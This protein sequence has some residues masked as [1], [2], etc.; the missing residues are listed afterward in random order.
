VSEGT[1]GPPHP[2]GDA[3]RRLEADQAAAD[4]EQAAS[5]ADQ[6]ASDRDQAAADADQAASDRDQAQAAAD[7]RASDRDQRAADRD[8]ASR[9][10]SAEATRAYEASRAARREGTVE[11]AEAGWGRA[12]SAAERLEHAARRDEN[13]RLRDLS[14]AARDRAAEERDREA[15]RLEHELALSSP[16]GSAARRHAAAVRIRAAADRAAAAADRERAAADRAAAAADREQA[17]AELSRAHM[18][19]LTG[20]YGRELGQAALA[21]EINRA[22]HG[23][24]R[25]VLAFVDVDDLKQVNDRDGHAAGDRLLRDVVGAI[26][27]HLRSYDP[28]VRMGGDEFV[29]ALADTGLED[30]RQRFREI[31]ASLDSRHPQASISVGFAALRPGETLDHLTQRGDRDLL[32]AKHTR[33]RRKRHPRKLA[34]SKNNR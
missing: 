33:M 27:S 26:Q 10:K 12:R 1:T 31:Q 6:I 3:A 2:P 24:G 7:Q 23:N 21:H 28:V 34:F 30:A 20:A 32:E 25:L 4:L 18:D 11:R 17:R 19:P 15:D 8:F 9:P 14:A 16:A 29:C 5:D 22:R 13:A